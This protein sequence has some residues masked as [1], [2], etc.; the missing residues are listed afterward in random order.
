VEFVLN[1]YQ[2][3]AMKA[4]FV[5]PQFT[6]NH[7]AQ[8]KEQNLIKVSVLRKHRTKHIPNYS[9]LIGDTDN[10]IDGKG[11]YQFASFDGDAEY[12][13]LNTVDYDYGEDV[14]HDEVDEYAYV[15]AQVR[16]FI[17]GNIS[18]E[19]DEMQDAYLCELEY[20]LNN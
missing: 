20:Q 7:M 17:D 3:L 15:H 14:F 13:S 1:I 19:D 11:I 12:Y 8:R 9:M 6:A 16:D 10:F 4:H 5:C 18:D 2:E